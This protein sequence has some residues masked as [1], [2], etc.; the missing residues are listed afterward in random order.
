MVV[1]VGAVAVVVVGAVA[2]AVAVVVAVV[3]VVVVGVAVVNSQNH[4]PDEYREILKLH[5]Q[6]LPHISMCYYCAGECA[7]TF[8]ES[9]KRPWL[10][11]RVADWDGP[12]ARTANEIREGK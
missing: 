6:A 3:V 7:G 10:E 12:V 2:V 5:A 11:R 8:H 9:C 4:T 1:G